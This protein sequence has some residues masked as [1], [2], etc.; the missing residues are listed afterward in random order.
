M[1]ER[2]KSAE[3]K[4]EYSQSYENLQQKHWWFR[5]RAVILRNYMATFIGWKSDMNVLEIGVGPGE[6]LYQLYPKGIKLIGLEPDKLNAAR[7]VER[8]P[9]K[10]YCGSIENIPPDVTERSYDVICMF[11]V[12]EHIEN[13]FAALNSVASL[14]KEGGRLVISVPAYQWMWGLQDEV[15]HHFRRYTEKSI[16]RRL[17]DTG[18]KICRVTYFNTFLFPFIAS[19]RL[20]SKY[21]MPRNDHQSDFDL[22]LGII[23]HALYAIFRS[24]WPLLRVFKFQFGVSLLLIA[25]KR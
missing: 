19:A 20:F 12:L 14:L 22:S 6:N 9:V 13:D 5:A 24:E 16:S 17:N 15:S 3:M 11:D 10:V 7:A 18:F 25:T 21:I 1:G 23:D 8:G 2:K 4:A